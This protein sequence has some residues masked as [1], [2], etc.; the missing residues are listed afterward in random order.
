M[1]WKLIKRNIWLEIGTVKE[2]VKKKNI[3]T[4]IYIVLENNNFHDFIFSSFAFQIVNTI[5]R[6]Y[7]C[8]VA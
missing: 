7:T 3:E 1:E 5:I 6:I 2:N 8:N 4:I